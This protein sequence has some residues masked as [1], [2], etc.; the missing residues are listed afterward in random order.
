MHRRLLALCPATTRGTPMQGMRLWV[1]LLL[2]YCC[3]ALNVRVGG[4]Y[5][6]KGLQAKKR[7]DE[8]TRTAFL[9]ITSDNSRV[10]G[11]CT[12]LQGPHI[13]TILSSLPCCVLHRIAFPVVSKWCQGESWGSSRGSGTYTLRHSS[14]LSPS[15][16]HLGF[17]CA[18][19]SA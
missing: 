12:G 10:A 13:L 17:A 2:P 11:G 14:G 19:C 3:Q 8:R 4:S 5:I 1:W 18:S 15:L 9:L 7:A 16:W 6:S